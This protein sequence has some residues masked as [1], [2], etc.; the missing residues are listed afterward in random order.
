M[1]SQGNPTTRITTTGTT[2]PFFY[3]YHTDPNIFT[4]D[5]NNRLVP[6]CFAGETPPFPGC[7]IAYNYSAINITDLP[8]GYTYNGC[9][10][11]NGDGFPGILPP[12]EECKTRA[13]LDS[14]KLRIAVLE[15]QKDG[16]NKEELLNELYYSP[17]ALETYQRYM[18]AG[19]YL[20]DEV[21]TEVAEHPLLSPT[22]KAN[23]LL[24]NAP[25]S[26]NMMNIAYQHV[27]T[28]VYQMLYAIKHYLKISDR[29]RLD[30][31]I[32]TEVQ[33]KEGLFNKLFS[34]YLADKDTTNLYSFLM[35]ENTP[36]T[37]RCLIGQ[38]CSNGNYS[39]AQTLLNSLPA[40]T[41]DEQD[42]KIVQQINLQFQSATT[43][44][45]SLSE[46]QYQN[47][48]NIA[49]AQ[50]FQSPSACALLSLLTGEHC[51]FLVPD[52]FENGKTG[53]PPYPKVSLVDLKTANKLWVQP[54]PIK[55]QT[56]IFIPAF[57][58]EE[59]TCLQVFDIN[60]LLLQQI[61][62]DKG[63]TVIMLDTEKWA[64]GLYML[65]LQS[66]NVR[67]AQTKLMVQH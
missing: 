11:L 16:G 33:K 5:A 10:D 59:N 50:S 7:A 55:S 29:D 36:Y 26:N 1:D 52:D 66:G 8:T 34:K 45:F 46:S 35:S 60:G 44:A 48:R 58:F 38:K 43:E 57:L 40:N 4:S 41:S 21:L 39:E 23:I 9:L 18:D 30:M 20:T 31:R 32:G 28:T 51:E 3:Y 61:A 22:R 64:N 17:E 56:N 19:P 14:L 47:L 27:S 37:L 65:T 49:D 13:C 2:S 53:S 12:D 42:Y 15:T 6:H 62:L 25:L 24:A 54:N 63:Q 67:L